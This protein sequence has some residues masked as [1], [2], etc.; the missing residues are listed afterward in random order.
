LLDDP[1]ELD[2]VID[3]VDTC[4]DGAWPA[5][6]HDLLG[7]IFVRDLGLGNFG[8]DVTGGGRGDVDAIC[9]ELLDPNHDL[10]L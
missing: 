8:G 1:N 5:F 10:G 9:E 2:R 4:S 3:L 6:E 7:Q